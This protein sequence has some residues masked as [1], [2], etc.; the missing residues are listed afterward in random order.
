MAI[1]EQDV[2]IPILDDMACEANETVN[3]AL[4]TPTGGAT[5]GIPARRC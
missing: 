4:S 1:D 5:L 2:A 3:L